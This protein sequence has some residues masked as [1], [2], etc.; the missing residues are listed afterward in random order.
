MGNLRCKSGDLAIVRV[1]ASGNLG[2]IVEVVRP[3]P[4]AEGYS[5]EWD[6]RSVGAE[7][8]D[9]DGRIVESFY[10]EDCC[11]TPITGLPLE[12][13]VETDVEDGHHV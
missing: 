7:L 12:F 11:L 8:V 6:A 3:A 10:I 1:S 5:F 4:P 9:C 2:R 13:L